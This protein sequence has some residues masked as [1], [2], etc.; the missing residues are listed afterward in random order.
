[1]N[2]NK[3]PTTFSSLNNDVIPDEEFLNTIENPMFELD[4]NTRFKIST[5]LAVFKSPSDL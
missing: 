5:F 3:I 4:S 1:M 2:E